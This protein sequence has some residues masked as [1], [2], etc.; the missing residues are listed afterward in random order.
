MSVGESLG[1][2]SLHSFAEYLQHHIESPEASSYLTTR[3]KAFMELKP[4][5]LNI[6]ASEMSARKGGRQRRGNTALDFP[7][8]LYEQYKSDPEESYNQRKNR[9][10][11][12]RRYWAEEWFKYRL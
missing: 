12:I 6:M 7:P 8:G 3:R 2:H 5:S 10:Q 9:I 11:W 1:S 4:I